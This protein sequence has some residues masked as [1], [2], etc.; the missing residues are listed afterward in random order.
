VNPAGAETPVAMQEPAAGAPEIWHRTCG[1]DVASALPFLQTLGAA[2]G[3]SRHR[4]HITC[5][6]GLQLPTWVLASLDMIVSEAIANALEHAFPADRDGDVWVRLSEAEGRISLV[7][8]DNGIGLPDLDH[9]PDSGRGL[10]ETLAQRLG[11]Y[12]RLGS[13]P[14]GG[15]QVSVIFPREVE[16]AGRAA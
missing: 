1:R 4:I 2:F 3:G 14:F 15:G 10:I 12:A 5:D 6:A 8:R 13:A 11:G 7:I 16:A 9:A